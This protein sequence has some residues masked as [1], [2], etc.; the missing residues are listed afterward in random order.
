MRYLLSVF[1][2]LPFLV[3]GQDYIDQRYDRQRILMPNVGGGCYNLDPNDK[4]Y[5][6]GTLFDFND[7]TLRMMAVDTMRQGQPLKY[8]TIFNVSQICNK[9]GKLVAYFN[10]QEL[11]DRYGNKILL[12]QYYSVEE[13]SYPSR[14]DINGSI[15][16][17]FPGRDSTYVLVSTDD[18]RFDNISG[19]TLAEDFSAVIFK[20]R[21]DGLLQIMNGIPTLH[22]AKYCFIGAITANRHANGRDWWLVAP[23]RRGKTFHVFLLDPQGIRYHHSQELDTTILYWSYCPVFS[24][25][26]QW[27]SRTEIVHT[28]QQWRTIDKI[29]LFHFDRCSGLFSEP[30]EIVFPVSDTVGVGQVLFDAK[31]QYYYIMRVKEIYQG[32]IQSEF[33]LENLI[34]LGSVNFN[35]PDA[36]LWSLIGPGFLAPNGKVYTFDGNNNFRSSIIHNPSEEGLACGF[37]Y[38]G[39]VKPSCT[40][41]SF[42]NMPDFNLGPLDGSACDTLGLDNPASVTGEIVKKSAPVLYPNPVGNKLYGR[43]EEAWTNRFVTVY[44]FSGKKVWHGKAAILQSGLDIS[45]L[46]AGV[47]FVVIQGAKVMK[48]VKM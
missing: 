6:I 36:N 31:S 48:V 12:E 17:P 35:L 30:S 29:Q 38:T 24:P 47:Y 22:K 40:G 14:Y 42:G 7:D 5:R 27:Y 2:V 21:Y 9:E 43:W 19:V 4:I 44:D 13:N 25:D 46:S 3:F 33:T 45:H 39:L 10:G 41:F 32:N 37:E 8:Y 23:E 16:L 28:G 26:G 20:E 11:W 1:M 34:K 18:H 15:I